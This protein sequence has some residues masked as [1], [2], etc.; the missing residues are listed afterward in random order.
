MPTDVRSG[1]VCQA[2]GLTAI[3]RVVRFIEEAG[4]PSERR[5][6]RDG[7]LS[8]AAETHAVGAGIGLGFM[9]ASTGEWRYL[10]VLLE[11]VL[12]GN[13]GET[14]LGAT[15]LRDILKERHYFLS[16]LVIGAMV[17]VWIRVFPDLLAGV[18][19]GA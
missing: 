18:M 4:A 3:D 13:R 2:C 16:G 10:G 12:F 5:T 15:L 9:I 6:D 11:L 17:G 19:P 7:F 1:R 14:R 8:Y